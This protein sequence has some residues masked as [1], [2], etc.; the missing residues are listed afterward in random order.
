[1]AL[2]RREEEREEE[3][4]RREKEWGKEREERERRGR[5]LDAA[6]A[7]VERLTREL[8][9]MKKER[10]EEAGR[11]REEE[12]EERT[13]EGRMKAVALDNERLRK[14]VEAL[15]GVAKGDDAQAAGV[16]ELHRLRREKAKLLSQR[17]EMVA[18]FKKQM[19]LIDV[20]K[21]QKMHLEAAKLLAFTEQEFTAAL[22]IT[23][24]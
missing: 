16:E 6:K 9:G 5:E 20:L 2:Q 13:R 14:R 22:D 7:E 21:R 11:R 18:A 17:A 10:G 4:R 23:D 12:R 1:M 24:A 8:N 3:R 15:E 19:K